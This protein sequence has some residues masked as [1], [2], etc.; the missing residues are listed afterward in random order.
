[1]PFVC[2]VYAFVSCC[3]DVSYFSVFITKDAFGGYIG[4]TLITQDSAVA[5]ISA[6]AP[7]RLELI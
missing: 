2:I 6:V 3:E 1:M 5:S 4:D 7:E